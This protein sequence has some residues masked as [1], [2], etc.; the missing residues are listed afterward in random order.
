MKLKTASLIAAIGCTLLLG[1]F[2]LLLL[3]TVDFF[4]RQYLF[5]ALIVIGWG[6]LINFFL[7]LHKNQK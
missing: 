2:I 1:M 4:L 5:I 3:S 6:S 7:I